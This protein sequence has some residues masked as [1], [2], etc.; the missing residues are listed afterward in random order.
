[1]EVKR[2]YL[3][4]QCREDSALREW[5]KWFIVVRDGYLFVYGNTNALQAKTQHPIAGAAVVFAEKEKVT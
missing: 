4:V 5:K 3:H 2:G 1:M